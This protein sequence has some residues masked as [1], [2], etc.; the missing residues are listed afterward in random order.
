MAGGNTTT[1]ILEGIFRLAERPDHATRWL[2]GKFEEGGSPLGSG[3]PWISWKAIDYLNK[4]DFRG[5][6]VYEYGGGGSTIYFA[7]RGARVVTIETNSDW[8]TLID[9]AVKRHKLQDLVTIET[10]DLVDGQS[11][12]RYLDHILTV[13]PWDVVLIDGDDTDYSGR[14]PYPISRMECVPNVLKTVRP[15]C[16]AIVDDSWRPKYLSARESFASATRRAFRGL[17]P[18]RPGVTQTDIYSF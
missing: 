1:R 15:G 3:L 16:M 11:K 5:K 14:C 17:G 2:R 8:T 10:I 13:D 18:H 12:Q 9:D 4:I 7:K 6:L